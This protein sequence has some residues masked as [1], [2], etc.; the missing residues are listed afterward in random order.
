MDIWNQ[1]KTVIFQ[2]NFFKVPLWLWFGPVFNLACSAFMFRLQ[3]NMMPLAIFLS[4]IGIF[5]SA[6]FKLKGVIAS[7]VLLTIF[8]LI[9]Y[10]NISDPIGTY[11][12]FVFGS[13][14]SF[15]I[16]SYCVEEYES[17][18]YSQAEDSKKNSEDVKLWQ[19]RFEANQLRLEREKERVDL[20]AKEYENQ[21]D[22]YLERI[23]QLEKMFH[24]SSYELK[25]EQNRG[26]NLH[27]ELKK[28][29][30]ERYE[31]HVKLE[32]SDKTFTEL[33][34]KIAFL[35]LQIEEQRLEHEREINEFKEQ[36]AIRILENKSE[37]DEATSQLTPAEI[38][39][40]ASI[41]QLIELPKINEELPKEDEEENIYFSSF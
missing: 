25:Q 37:L 6:E 33:N 1:I 12:L 26:L 2:R 24:S 5:L 21:E 29:L 8:S 34:E 41:Q 19:S 9:F 40:E 30:I 4:V 13:M 38:I 23:D 3:P 10:K 39:E 32:N 22:V 7:S 28:L 27:N 20:L 15:L 18:I 11:W 16:N 36:F 17:F 35:N 31:A 14:T